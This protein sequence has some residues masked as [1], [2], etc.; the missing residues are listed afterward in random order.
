MNKF[1]SRLNAGCALLGMSGVALS[2][3]VRPIHSAIHWIAEESAGLKMAPVALT[4][5][6]AI[7]LIIMGPLILE[8]LVHILNNGLGRAFARVLSFWLAGLKSG[9]VYLL[10]FLPFI[11]IQLIFSHPAEPGVVTHGSPVKL[12]FVIL[13]AVF[14]PFWSLLLIRHFP[15][16]VLR[17]TL[18]ERFDSKNFE[19]DSDPLER[20]IRDR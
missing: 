13:L 5:I 8:A 20:P 11:I 4:A 14:S 19:S 16:V 7:V 15:E 9:I 18:F 17:G 10:L 1:R 3:A 12:I 2:L 6:E